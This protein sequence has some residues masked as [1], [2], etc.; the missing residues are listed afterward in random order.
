MLLTQLVR[1]EILSRL[2]DSQISILNS[3]VE[4]ELVQ[5]ASIRRAL[6]SATQPVTKG[7]SAAGAARTAG[8]KK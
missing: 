6:T 1:P 2:T 7:L 4:A 3:V 5:N 8:K